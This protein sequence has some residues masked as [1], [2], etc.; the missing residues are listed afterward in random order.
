MRKNRKEKRG[1]NEEKL[2]LHVIFRIRKQG[3]IRRKI[4]FLFLFSIIKTIEISFLVPISIDQFAIFPGDGTTSS[5]EAGWSNSVF[6]SIEW[7]FLGRRGINR[8]SW[9][10]FNFHS[11]ISNAHEAG[12]G[13]YFSCANRG[14][15]ISVA[16]KRDRHRQRSR[17]VFRSNEILTR[18]FSLSMSWTSFPRLQ[19]AWQFCFI[20]RRVVVSRLTS[21]S[22]D[23]CFLFFC[24][25]HF[26][27]F[28]LRVLNKV[29][30]YSWIMCDWQMDTR[31][32][33]IGYNW[34]I[35]VIYSQNRV[36]NEFK[37]ENNFFDS[38]L[39]INSRILKIDFYE[40]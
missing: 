18:P 21:F 6:F 32:E 40:S 7:L 20:P 34:R 22:S 15:E 38:L 31:Y 14:V 11:W 3:N 23:L 8:P 17:L 13:V 33:R 37:V 25:Y 39:Q 16:P 35:F 5:N 27:L 36:N 28:Y 19:F 30:S 9:L 1:K 26:L 4:S 29:Y 10:I 12:S 24:F 2:F